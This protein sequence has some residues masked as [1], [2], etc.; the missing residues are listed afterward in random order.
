MRPILAE[1]AALPA[2]RAA[3]VLNERTSTQAAPA[4]SEVIAFRSPGRGRRQ[5]AQRRAEF[6]AV[7]IRADDWPRVRGGGGRQTRP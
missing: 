3:A 7:L 1:L 4:S 2:N 6:D 5:D